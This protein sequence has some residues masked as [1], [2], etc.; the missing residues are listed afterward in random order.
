MAAEVIQVLT[1]GELHIKEIVIDA[2]QTDSGGIPFK[3]NYGFI[4]AR[5]DPNG[6]FHIRG[7]IKKDL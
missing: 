7:D 4:I 2:N 3:D 5:L 1:V 6:N